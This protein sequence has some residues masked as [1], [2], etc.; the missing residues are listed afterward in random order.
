MIVINSTVNQ[1]LDI[2]N[3]L[4]VH[5]LTGCDTVAPYFGTGETVALNV[6]QSGAHTLSCIGDTNC[7]LSDIISQAISFIFA[8]CGQTKCMTMT[9]VRQKTWVK[10][11]SWSIVSTQKLFSL[12][13]TTDSFAQ[14][15]ARVH[16]QVAV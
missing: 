8:C 1:H 15:A 12:L 14:N 2:P 10:K 4:A 13:L 16:I 7:T 9:E 3:L 11:V 5:G 6:F